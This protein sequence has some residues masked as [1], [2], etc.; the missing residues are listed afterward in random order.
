M[1]GVAADQL[2]IYAV[3][4]SSIAVKFVQDAI[5]AFLSINF[6]KKQKEIL[7]TV[8]TFITTTG[9]F[10][11]QVVEPTIQSYIAL[12]MAVYGGTQATHKLSKTM[13]KNKS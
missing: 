13:K 5:Q 3:F 7:S 6:K 9:L 10:F 2:A 8:L 4:V 12:L 1:L 11:T